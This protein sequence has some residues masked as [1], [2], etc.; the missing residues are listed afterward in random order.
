M[1]K[2]FKLF[3]QYNNKSIE[4]LVNNARK[5]SL[6]NFIDEYVYLNDIT[7]KDILDNVKEG[8]TVELVRELKDDKGNTIRDESGKRK[9]IPYKVVTATKYYSSVWDFILDNTEELKKEAE[10]LF[11][12]NKNKKSKKIV[13]KTIEAYHASP[14]KFDMFKYGDDKTSAQ[15]GADSGFFFFLDKKYAEYYS[16]VIKDN[17]GKS[18]LYT[19]NV[20]SDNI[21]KLKGEDIGTNWGRVGELQSAEA[22]GY[23]G[24]IIKDADTGYGIADELVVFDSDNIEIKSIED[25]E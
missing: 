12:K 21:L 7:T 8:D 16:S 25:N 1:N 24:V 3:E 15:L 5:W 18:Y 17:K 11:Y 20:K 9:T 4:T 19:V 13:G 6:D 23:D 14:N 22:E 2:Y 10:D